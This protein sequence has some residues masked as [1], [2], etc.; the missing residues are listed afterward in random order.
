MNTPSPCHFG[1]AIVPFP[2]RMPDA[3]WA[4]FEDDLTAF[5]DHL[6]VEQLEASQ[7][8]MILGLERTTAAVI[9]RR[10]CPIGIGPPKLQP[11]P[12]LRRQG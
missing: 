11:L 1:G 12:P 7:E 6:R 3:F 8:A 9:A 2:R 10:F 5:V 4:A